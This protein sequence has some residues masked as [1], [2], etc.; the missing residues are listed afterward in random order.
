MQ[1]FWCILYSLYGLLVSGW[2]YTIYTEFVYYKQFITLRKRIYAFIL[3]ALFSFVFSYFIYYLALSS[4]N[5]V[6]IIFVRLNA[7]IS[8]IKSEI[9]SSRLLSISFTLLSFKQG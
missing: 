3:F 8:S 6:Y 1:F 5:K 7:F 9:I 2:S 4:K